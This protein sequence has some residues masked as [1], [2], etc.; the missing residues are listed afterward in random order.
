MD[1]FKACRHSTVIKDMRVSCEL[2]VIGSYHQRRQNVNKLTVTTHNDGRCLSPTSPAP[3]I[4]DAFLPWTRHSIR[5]PTDVVDVNSRT[6][7][8][9]ATIGGDDPSDLWH[10]TNRIVA[11]LLHVI[12]PTFGGGRIGDVILLDIYSG[13]RRVVSSSHPEYIASWNLRRYVY[14]T[15]NLSISEKY[16]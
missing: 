15:K 14:D 7:N 1:H 11:I 3:L 10:G 4:R 13:K 6:G 16:G 5:I 12:R 8:V 9:A 2:L